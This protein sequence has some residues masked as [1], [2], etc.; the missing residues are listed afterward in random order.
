MNLSDAIQNHITH[1]ASADRG[2]RMAIWEAMKSAGFGEVEEASIAI[3]NGH[4]IIQTAYFCLDFS[5]DESQSPSSP[6]RI[7]LGGDIDSGSI[8]L[9]A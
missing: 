2:L 5:D 1:I 4:E 8:I 7:M 3:V 9:Y 6:D